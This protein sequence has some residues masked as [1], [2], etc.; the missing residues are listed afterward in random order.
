MAAA[1]SAAVAVPR[2]LSG[3]AISRGTSVCSPMWLPLLSCPTAGHS[4]FTRDDGGNVAARPGCR[5]PRR[6]RSARPSRAATRC[7]FRPPSPTTTARRRRQGLTEFDGFRWRALVVDAAEYR[8]VLRHRR[9]RHAVV[10]A[11]RAV[12]PARGGPGSTV[13]WREAWA[14]VPTRERCLRR[15]RLRRGRRRR[16]GAGARLPPRA[17]WDRAWRRF[18][19]TCA[20]SH[21]NHTPFCPPSAL[22]VLPAD[23]ANELMSGLAG[24]GA[25]GFHAQRWADEF[26]SCAREMLGAAPPT[27]I[28]PAA[29][30][31]DDIAKV[32]ASEECARE[33][34][35]LDEQLGDRH[36][37][38]RVD[39][40][41]L[42]KNLL[43]GFL[44]FEDLLQTRPEW[45]GRVVFGAFIYPSREA[46][47][48]YLAYHVEVDRAGPPHQRRVG[49]CRL[50]ADHPRHRR[51]L[52]P[53]V[54]GAAAL[55]RAAGESRP[56]RAQPGRQGGLG[57][58][59]RNGVLALSR[60]AGVWEELQGGALDVNPFDV[61]GTADVLAE[62]L[63]DGRRRATAGGPTSCAPPPCGARRTTG[64]TNSCAPP[65]RCASSPACAKMATT[66]AGP[67]RNL[68]GSLDELGRRFGRGRRRP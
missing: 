59:E 45:R 28:A 63:G 3:A 51:L 8:H 50:D 32:A 57:L 64:S 14:R 10:P 26:D 42:S 37:I 46:L 22:R 68:V 47:P 23:V 11:S 41:E 60:E 38:V 9:Q 52:P 5:R 53:L 21:F 44:A 33:L 55:R 67:S 54:R 17:R 65:P 34:A 16:H 19:P 56:R 30:D 7:G 18:A 12:R 6:R 49:H 1:T 62:A 27:F 2:N 20:R 24:F 4:S 40:I 31:H 58:N 29:T 35:Q 25:C 15:R 61:A 43:R 13:G 36:F 39:R 66:A 48:E